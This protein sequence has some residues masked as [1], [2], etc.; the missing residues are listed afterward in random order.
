MVSCPLDQGASSDQ[1]TYV[2]LF[3]MLIDTDCPGGIGPVVQDRSAATIV[4]VFR[5][6]LVHLMPTPACTIARS[7]AKPDSSADTLRI[8]WKLFPVPI[9]ISPDPSS[10]SRRRRPLNPTVLGG[11]GGAGNGD[12]DPPRLNDHN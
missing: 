1:N 2:P 12:I 9:S 8:D 6:L 5:P 11:G 10:G 7:G 4:C 3:S